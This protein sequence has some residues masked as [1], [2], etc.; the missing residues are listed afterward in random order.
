[1]PM[2]TLTAPRN[3]KPVTPAGGDPAALNLPQDID[4]RLTRFLKYSVLASPLSRAG[5][6]WES[7]RQLEHL[8][9]QIW[10]AHEFIELHL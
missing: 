2:S 5:D 1:M 4:E 9:Q 3:E 8:R 10:G 7:Y 6:A